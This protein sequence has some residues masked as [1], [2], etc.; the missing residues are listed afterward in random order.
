MRGPKNMFSGSYAA[1]ESYSLSIP[2][3]PNINRLQV[4]RYL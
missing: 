4:F 3:Q 1:H 2:A